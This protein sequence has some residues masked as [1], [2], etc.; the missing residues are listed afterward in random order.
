M[1]PEAALKIVKFGNTKSNRKNIIGE[2]EMAIYLS[3][4]YQVLKR[5]LRKKSLGMGQTPVKRGV[6]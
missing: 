5:F 1:I 2:V 3:K 6:E 4:R